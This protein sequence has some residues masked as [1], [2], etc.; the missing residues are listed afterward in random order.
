MGDPIENGASGRGE[1]I[2]GNCF[3]LYDT[4]GPKC[5]YWPS[6]YRLI[7]LVNLDLR[8]AVPQYSGAGS[9]GQVELF[10]APFIYRKIS[11]SPLLRL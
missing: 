10:E 1:A 6:Q 8:L 7:V 4:K 11:P 3:E 5:Y 2:S 9:F